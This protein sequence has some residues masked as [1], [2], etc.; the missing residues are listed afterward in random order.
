MLNKIYHQFINVVRCYMNRSAGCD[1][2]HGGRVE[3]EVP[4]WEFQLG[5]SNLG[6][7]TWEFPNRHRVK[8]FKRWMGVVEELRG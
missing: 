8:G 2:G 3:G 7:P 5:S 6:V 4:T 1:L